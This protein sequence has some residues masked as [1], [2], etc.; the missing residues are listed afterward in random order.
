MKIA[1]S[2]AAG[3]GKTTLANMIRLKRRK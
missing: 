3:T 2:G 1:I